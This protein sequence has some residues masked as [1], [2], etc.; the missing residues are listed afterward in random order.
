MK[1]AILLILIVLFVTNC[2]TSLIIN[3]SSSN[4]NSSIVLTGI[5]IYVQSDTLGDFSGGFSTRV[6]AYQNDKEATFTIVNSSNG[7]FNLTIP[8]TGIY[9]I[10][11]ITPEDFVPI[12]ITDFTIQAGSNFIEDTVRL[13][14]FTNPT[15]DSTNIT[16]LFKIGVSLQEIREII[17][18]SGCEIIFMI[19]SSPNMGTLCILKI[20]DGKSQIEKVEE[21]LRRNKVKSA[22]IG[23]VLPIDE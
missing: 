1:S 6:S 9:D 17:D 16:V 15:N 12:K 3:S 5:V 21:F 2:D 22:Q 7:D 4:S 23:S 8:Q 14:A 13:S 11:F 20:V 10:V 18:Q 19:S